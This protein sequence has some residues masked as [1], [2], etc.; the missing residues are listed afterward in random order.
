M[1]K[2]STMMDKKGYLTYVKKERKLV[3]VLNSRIRKCSSCVS[4]A[5]VKYC[6]MLTQ[7][8]RKFHKTLYIGNRGI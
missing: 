6:F 2:Q 8:S 7:S 3:L 4:K 5:K 1:A